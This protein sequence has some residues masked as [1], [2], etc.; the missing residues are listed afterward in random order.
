MIFPF[1]ILNITQVLC[2][3]WF[4]R[5]EPVSFLSLFLCD[6]LSK[7]Q[8]FSEFSGGPPGDAFGIRLKLRNVW[9]DVCQ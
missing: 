9:F 2:F 1:N 5:S 6:G 7:L 3:V 4:L 8:S